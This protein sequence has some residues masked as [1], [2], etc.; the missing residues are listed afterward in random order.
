MPIGPGNV[1]LP[2]EDG[3]PTIFSHA[4]SDGPQK[5]IQRGQN[6]K[7]SVSFEAAPALLARQ[8]HAVPAGL[9]FNL[10][11]QAKQAGRDVAKPFHVSVALQEV[12]PEAHVIP[13]L[14]EDVRAVKVDQ[15][16]DRIN[17]RFGQ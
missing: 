7:N 1:S 11:S 2:T 16:A 6:E 14:F 5:P 12:I 9:V 13:S 17:D 8:S 10:W 4:P 15:S 3:A